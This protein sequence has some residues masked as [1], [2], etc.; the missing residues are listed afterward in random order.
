MITYDVNELDIPKEYLEIYQTKITEWEKVKESMLTLDV[1]M[2][3]SE[4]QSK[5]EQYHD[6]FEN[7]YIA[8]LS[9]ISKF[10]ST[11]FSS[12]D[13]DSA[14]YY[15]QVEYIANQVSSISINEKGVIIL[16]DK[17]M[18]DSQKKEYDKV[19]LNQKIAGKSITEL[20]KSTNNV[21][22]A[23]AIRATKQIVKSILEAEMLLFD[24]E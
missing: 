24:I 4:L 6:Y 7:T 20:A 23:Q 2:A 19:F 3:K 9:L 8:I 18:T 17:L 1:E 22:N 16:P 21:E 5:Y 14:Q 15:Q 13:M 10:G 11:A 12:N